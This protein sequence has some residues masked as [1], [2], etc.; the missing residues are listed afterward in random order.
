MFLPPLSRRAGCLINRSYYLRRGLRLR[1]PKVS[2]RVLRLT[3]GFVDRYHYRQ[4]VSPSKPLLNLE[5]PPTDEAVIASNKDYLFKTLGFGEEQFEI[6]QT[7]GTHILTL[8]NGIL[9]DRVNWLKERL[10]LD[11]DGITRFAQ[12]Y[13][14]ILGYS[15]M[16]QMEPML[17]WLQKRLALDDAALSKVIQKSWNT[18]G[19]SITNE[20]EPKLN[21]FQQRLSL[22]DTDLSNVVKR[23]PHIM[24][25]SVD[26]L[27]PLMD[28]VQQRLSL[29][30][31]ELSIFVKRF[32]PLLGYSVENN[33]EPTLNFY[34]DA[35]GDEEEA[36]ALIK[37][38]P[39]FFGRS[40]ENRLKPRLEEAREA[41]LVID[42]KCLKSVAYHPEKK[43]DAFMASQAAKI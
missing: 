37:Q 34:V 27:E 7:K 28:W 30:D 16:E 21:W 5:S 35:F 26:K 43:W 17:A 36:L 42:A 4:Y 14:T 33:L 15:I 10:G 19:N 6:L 12:K 22:D 3:G 1:S 39:S 23:Y 31:D 41:G 38:N 20:L 29:T 40:L 24:W 25:L 13:P 2:T 32:P 9:E 8:E 18:L 11:Q